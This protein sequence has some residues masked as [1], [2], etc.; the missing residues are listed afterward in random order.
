MYLEKLINPCVVAPYCSF[1]L[2]FFFQQPENVLIDAT[3]GQAQIKLIDFGDAMD[4]WSSPPPHFH[5]LNANPEFSAPELLNGDEICLRNRHVVSVQCCILPNI[6]RSIKHSRSHLQI[7]LN[8][9]KLCKDEKYTI[10]I[11]NFIV[12]GC[13]IFK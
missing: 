2:T 11:C 6:N 4:L 13:K 10:M 8:I 7:S 5:E 9:M 12:V 1:S 3:S